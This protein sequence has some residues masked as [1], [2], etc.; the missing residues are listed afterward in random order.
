MVSCVPRQDCATGQSRA[1]E[2]VGVWRGPPTRK[3]GTA[4]QAVLRPAVLL[5]SYFK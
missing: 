3:P 5:V 4:L 2:P 1:L